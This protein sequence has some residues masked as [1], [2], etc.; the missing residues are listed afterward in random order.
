MPFKIFDLGVINFQ[1]AEQF[2]KEVFKAVK[3]NFLK[4]ALILC[5]HYPVI[6]LGRQAKKLNIKASGEELKKK[7]IPLYG[8]ERG[9]DVTYHGP[10]QLMVYPILNLTYLRRDISLFLRM[11]EELAM[12]VLSD[13]G[14][15]SQRRPGLTGVWVGER[16]IASIGIAIRNWITYYGLAINIKKDDLSNFSLIR[17]CGMDIMMTSLESVLGEE[18]SV[19]SVKEILIRRLQNDQS[20]LTGIR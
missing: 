20:S 7:G 9:G 16:K 13:F 15:F 17:P 5:Q 2:Q 8:I 1:K 19:D 11:L 4:S 6:T 18:V 14:I 3:N 10:G 12:Q